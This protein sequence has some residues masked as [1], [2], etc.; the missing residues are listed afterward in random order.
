MNV[1]LDDEKIRD[2]VREAA[3]RAAQGL[4]R[5]QFSDHGYGS[6]NKHHEK[7]RKVIADSVDAL[8]N[9]A[10]FGEEVVAFCRKRFLELAEEK[11]ANAVAR[12]SVSKLKGE[13]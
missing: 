4:V 6:R 3:L 10:E 13:A 7:I 12:T 9:S 1:E 11:I 2:L 5:E 8:I